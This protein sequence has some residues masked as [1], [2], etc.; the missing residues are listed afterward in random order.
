M[1]EVMTIEEMKKRYPDEWVLIGDYQTKPSSLEVVAGR[2]LA[3]NK[4][5]DAFDALV[6]AHMPGPV[7]IKCFKESPPDTEYLL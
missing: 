2:V 3:H 1:T 5:R 7:A 4:D 6:A